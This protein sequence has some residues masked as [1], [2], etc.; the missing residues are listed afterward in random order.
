MNRSS[1]PIKGV[2]HGTTGGYYAGCGCKLCRE[3]HANKEKNR[4]RNSPVA[5]QKHKN[6]NARYYIKNVERIKARTAKWAAAN[7]NRVKRNQVRWAAANRE[8]LVEKRRDWYIKNKEKVRINRTKWFAANA[9]KVKVYNT[10]YN[11]KRR[12][13]VRIEMQKLVH[14]AGGCCQRCGAKS[15]LHFHHKRASTKLDVISGLVGHHQSQEIIDAELKKCILLCTSCHT[16]V[17]RP[18]QYIQHMKRT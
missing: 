7:Q 12:A 9:E 13:R 10:K 14:A 17:H 15:N 5:R 1:T 16:K 18:W 8:K 11:A 3:A 2:K 4:L 6:Y